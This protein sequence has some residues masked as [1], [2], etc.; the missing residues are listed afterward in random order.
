MVYQYPIKFGLLATTTLEDYLFR[1][2]IGI[3]FVNGF[4][5]KSMACIDE[6]G[7]NERMAF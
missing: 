2:D 7:I 3:A 4:A 1:F 6:R 5:I